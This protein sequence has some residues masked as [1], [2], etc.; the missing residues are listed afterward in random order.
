[1][2]FPTPVPISIPEVLAFLAILFAMFV[3]T[4]TGFGSALISLPL[5]SLIFGAKFA[6]PFILTYECLIDVMILLRDRFA[7]RSELRRATP[8]LIGGVIGVLLGTEVLILSTEKLLRI[9]IGIS[10]IVF[11]LFLLWNVKLKIEGGRTSSA[12]AGLLGGF[13]CGS[14]GLP[15]PP[16]ALILSSQGLAK[17]A[18]R[19]SIVLF[20]T[21]IDLITFIYFIFVG[22]FTFD[23]LIQGLRLIPAL[24]LGFLLGDF[25]FRECN[26]VRFR[27]IVMIIIIISGMLS[28]SS[29]ISI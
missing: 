25:A 28:I 8:L 26:E 6:I 2:P 1:M 27:K 7:A 16:M 11:S 29:G 14:V 17:Q 20:L 13:L 19:R 10:L 21:I 4:M 9:I 5:L 18:F 15:G 3:R 12:L 22:L 23:M 24:I